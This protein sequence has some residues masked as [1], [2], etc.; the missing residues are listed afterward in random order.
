MLCHIFMHCA[1]RSRSQLVGV[2]S[3]CHS[4]SRLGVSLFQHLTSLI[5]NY[6]MH[7]S[8]KEFRRLHKV[9]RWLCRSMFS[10]AFCFVINPAEHSST[11]MLFFLLRLYFGVLNELTVWLPAA[12]EGERHR[13]SVCV[14]EKEGAWVACIAGRQLF[15]PRPFRSKNIPVW[16]HQF[17]KKW[18]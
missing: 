15:S 5:Q 7:I 2:S 18:S 3:G 4:N 12:P 9:T 11:V 13:K 8:L 6:M 1:A 16:C 10:F 17:W 14:R